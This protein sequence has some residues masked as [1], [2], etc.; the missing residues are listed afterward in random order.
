MNIAVYLASS[1]GTDSKIQEETK[2]LG[3]WIGKSHHALVYGGSKAGLM[4][5]IAQATKDAGGRVIGVETMLF[6]NRGQ[7][8]PL[9]DDFHIT[10]DL[11]ERKKTMMDLADIFIALPGGM[12]TLDEIVDIMCINKLSTTYRPIFFLNINGFYNDI[13]NQLNKMVEY[14]Y[15]SKHDRDLVSFVDDVNQL[16][17]SLNT[18]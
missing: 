1:F 6:Y 18:K 17:E 13:K 10:K 16:V 7:A 9:C 8:Y 3:T 2:A 4:E 11:A 12:G 14:G 15:L 5:T